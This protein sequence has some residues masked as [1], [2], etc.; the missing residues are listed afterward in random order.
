MAHRICHG[1]YRLLMI[2]LAPLALAWL[3]WRGGKEPGYREHLAQRLGYVDVPPEGTGGL[4]VHAASLG[5]VQAAGPL[6][7]ALRQHWPDRCITVSTQTPTGRAAVQALWGGGVRHLFA[8]LDTPAATARFLDRLQPQCL[9][10]LERELWPEL[11]RQC[12]TR[13]VPVAL[14][15]A[16]LSANSM[17]GYQRIAGLMQPVWAQLTRVAC[18]DLETMQRFQALG[19]DPARLVH[20]GNL[21]FDI[22]TTPPS[23]TAPDGLAGRTVIVAGSTHEDEETA[24]LQAWPAFA[25]AHPGALLVLVPRHPQRF[26]A[27]AQTLASNALPFVR[28]SLQQ[29]PNAHT[30]VLLGD[31]MGELTTWY[32]HARLCFIGGT[33]Q[34]RGGHNPLEALALGRPVL[35]GPHTRNFAALYAQLQNTGAGHRVASAQA[36]FAKASEWLADDALWACASQ[37]ARAFVQ[38]HSGATGRTV[39]ALAPLWNAV[40]PGL[41]RSVQELKQTNQVIWFDPQFGA[42]P[43][44]WFDRPEQP[45]QAALLA[46]GSGRGQA[47][48]IALGQTEG[49]LRHY[50]RG[51]FV[52]KISS[53]RYWQVLPHASR[54]MREFVLLRVLRSWGLPVPQPVAARYQRVGCS[55][56]ADIIVALIPESN[57]LV[58]RLVQAPLSAAEWAALGQAIRQLHDHQVFHADLNAHN[59]MLDTQGKAWIVD[60]D[61]CGVRAGDDWKAKNLERLLRSLRKEQQRL[62]TFHWQ[63]A[64]WNALLRAY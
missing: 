57:N 51:G 31:T 30:Q 53:D 3:W 19:V 60:F 37:A 48:K 50:R 16:R 33:L 42:A 22:A 29:T 23:A 8:P 2:V 43:T 54:A 18:A 26:E 46:T 52:A 7:E 15:N 39:A 38:S 61:Q 24:L 44:A 34:D 64:D 1:V 41:L 5:E 62:A 11:L 13:A 17:A 27:T 20:S 21:K 28:R 14:V 55:Y 63:E 59:L 32:Q 56:R 58:Q 10:L 36:L 6:I 4:W 9:L 12:R 25:A 35:F 40:H 45:S 49:V 47:L